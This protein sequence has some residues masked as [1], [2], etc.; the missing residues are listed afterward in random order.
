MSTLNATVPES[1]GH[2]LV[3]RLSEL[4]QER[5]TREFLARSRPVV[6]TGGIRHW[7]ALKQWSIESLKE[8]LA[9]RK[10]VVASAPRGIFSYD[11]ESSRAQYQTMDFAAATSLV[12]ECRADVKYYIMQISINEDLP[13]L[14]GDVNPPDLVFGGFSSPH[15][16]IGGE[17][18]ITPLHWD[19]CHNLYGQVRGRK[20]FTLFPPEDLDKLYPYPATALFAHMSYADPDDLARWPRLSEAQRTECILEPGDLLF[21]P[22][23]WWHQVRSLDP[24]ISVN[25]WWA[26]NLSH[27]FVPVFLRTLGAAYNRDRLSGL[28]SPVFNYPGG[29]IGAARAALRQGQRAFAILFAAAALERA[30]RSKCEVL[31]I[32]IAQ[33]ETPV[34]IQLLDAELAACAAYPPQLDRSR[35]GSWIDAIQRVADGELDAPRHSDAAVTVDEIAAFVNELV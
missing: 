10:V 12:S 28:G 21:L 35:L 8:R 30:V 2:R 32:D 29:P 25:F 22:A 18:V 31:G 4:S 16:W 7:P 26:P 11:L 23:F 15:L 3:E 6:V 24:S 1:L 9:G 33:G 17:G 14:S 5:F 19:N 20:R 27:C 13:E 34:P